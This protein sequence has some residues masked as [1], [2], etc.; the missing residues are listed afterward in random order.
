MVPGRGFEPRLAVP[1]TAV[2]PLDD[3]GMV[4]VIGLEPMAL[5]LKAPCSTTE[6]HAPN[7]ETGRD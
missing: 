3:P 6:L 1:K 2:L 7:G 5:E 4:G